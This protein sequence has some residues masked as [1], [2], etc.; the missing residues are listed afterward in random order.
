M[1]RSSRRAGVLLS[2]RLAGINGIQD[3][4]ARTDD[5]STFI[6][7]K[8]NMNKLR[9]AG[10]SLSSPGSSGVIGV[11]KNTVDNAIVSADGTDHP[12]FLLTRKPHAIEFNHCTLKL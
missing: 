3:R 2:P 12:T 9:T 6:I 8:V 5:P 7:Y 1:W 10:S 11:N 4:S